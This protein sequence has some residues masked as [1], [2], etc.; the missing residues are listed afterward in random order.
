MA[1]YETMLTV[2]KKGKLV[3]ADLPFRPGQQV[4][5]T[6]VTAEG[7]DRSELVRRWK[8]LFK[9]MQASSQAGRLTDAEIDEEIESYRAGL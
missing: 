9:N 4:K 5:I 6:I 8:V 1:A 7:M 3:L 2:D